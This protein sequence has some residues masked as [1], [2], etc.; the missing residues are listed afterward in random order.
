MPQ[1]VDWARL[2]DAA[3]EQLLAR[4]MAEIAGV[5]GAEPRVAAA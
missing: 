4:E 2:D 5:L 3:L 1:I